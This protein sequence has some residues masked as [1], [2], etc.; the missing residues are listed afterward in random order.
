[1]LLCFVPLYL[2]SSTAS[3]SLVNH[4]WKLWNENRLHEVERTFLD[5]TKADPN[6]QRAFFSLSYLYTLQ[7]KS[8]KAWEMYNS[9]VERSANQYPYLFAVWSS[10]KFRQNPAPEKAGII[11]LLSKI[12]K[13]EKAA[14]KLQASAFEMLGSY[15][16][17]RNDINTSKKYYDKIKSI[18]SWKLIGPF[19]NTSASGYDNIFPPETEFKA[20]RQYHGKNDI[21]V[22]WFDFKTIRNDRW[23][24]F[25]RYFGYDDAVFYANTFV[26]S[27]TKQNVQVRV[28]TSGSLKT[29]LNDQLIIAIHDEN[30]NDLDTYVAETELQAGW[31]RILIKCGYSEITNCNFMFR[32][33]D[34]NGIP[35]DNITVSTEPQ[36][37]SIVNN[38]PVTMIENFAERYLK[39]QL[40]EHPDHIENYFL[41]SDAYLRNDKASEAEEVV[42]RLLKM[43][44]NCSMAYYQLIE[45]YF[46]GEKG[47][48]VADIYEKLASLDPTIPS[49]IEYQYYQ[50]IKNEDYDNAEM[51]L[52]EYARIFP[53][54]KKTYVLYIDFY[55]KKKQVDQ[56][57]RIAN[58]AYTKYPD[59][60]Q[61]VNLR[62]AVLL[63][64]ERKYDSAISLI[65]DYLD[66]EYT[67]DG[68]YAL[69]EMYLRANNVKEFER[70]Y[71]KL[72][73]LMPTSPGYY[74][75]LAEVYVQLQQYANAEATVRKALEITPANSVCLEKLGT[76]LRMMDK[77]E[78]A[79]KTFR[80]ALVNQPTKYDSRENLRELESKPFIFS[81][82]RS[83]D[84][85]YVIK[86]APA[87]EK[88]PDDAAI[89]VLDDTKR[90][91]YPE[92]ASEYSREIV[93]KMFN[94][95]GVDYFKEYW[96]EYN[97]HSEN[98]IVERAVVIKK[99][100][101]ETKADINTNQIVFKSL[102]V[103]DVIH[104][105]WRVKNYYNGKLSRHFWDQVSFNGFLPMAFVR[106]S[107]IVPAGK[108]FSYRMQN[109]TLVPGIDSL[110]DGVR[111]T[112]TRE[113]VPS[114]DIEQNMPGT[115]DIGVMLH[116]S[117]IPSWDY[118]V[119][120]YSDLAREKTRSSY[121]I[122]EQIKELFA[123]KENAGQE[124][125]IRTIYNYITEKIRYSNVSFRQSAYIP[126]SA[127]NVMVHKL[128]DCKD[129]ATL[130]IAMLNEVGIHAY[131]VLVNT[132]GEGYNNSILPSIT[133]NHC[134]VAVETDSGTKYM[135]LT[136]Y[137]YPYGSI[138]EMDQGAF[139]LMIKPGVKEPFHLMPS[140]FMARNII[141][142]QELT[143][144]NDNNVTVKISSNRTG[145]PAASQR[146]T[147][148]NLAKKDQEK[149]LL[150][151][152]TDDYATVKIQSFDFDQLDTP[153]AAITFKYSLTAF[154]FVTKAGG[155]SIVKNIWTDKFLAIEALSYEKRDY[156]FYFYPGTDTTKETLTINFDPS[157]RPVDLKPSSVITSKF[158]DY[159]LTYSSA[160]G[161]ITGT[162]ECVFKKEIIQPEEYLEFKEFYNK[163][164]LEDAA[165]IVL[166]NEPAPKK[167]AKKTKQL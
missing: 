89:Y 64:T 52:Q 49:V 109:S 28:G 77:K 80:E 103:G 13:D 121:E 108:Q 39:E 26:F 90:V 161:V 95:R 75:Q 157:L 82:F 36:E 122:K 71:N 119:Q 25:T 58:E 2:F 106:Y 146:D 155:L 68:V 51:K 14:G 59:E 107:I 166:T 99:D 42:H 72:F 101:G 143:I 111:Y 33:T 9:G 88:Y 118:I 93:V 147:Y 100:G 35:L 74:L 141:R 19:D 94:S 29:F 138:P 159:K 151:W 164:L 124:E 149:Q 145:S 10:E 43:M 37:Y 79:K 154:N 148:R 127:R 84:I 137:N 112:W 163:V 38:A 152:L 67:T 54:D 44:P 158:G 117:S 22:A 62:S 86:H 104:I 131:H 24:D 5:A 81:N 162:R 70:E 167:T 123:G 57:I 126:Q 41:L 91:V 40:E 150:K 21:P 4:G 78:E 165:S 23:I 102:E 76:I 128:G 20:N 34:K 30:N 60:W 140:Q 156:P 31:N 113:N 142:T 27:K 144:G 97:S 153:A 65:E 1:M 85:G 15:Y 61:F 12:S 87:A 83:M 50:F 135:D 110:S 133:F 11:D 48:E 92:G 63:Q 114:I 55:S 130:C 7:S 45:T 56:L 105:K 46:R 136:A 8:G 115:N 73:E 17:K 132:R 66:R 129:V 134:I 116:I 16:E 160:K 120:W 53:G 139:A 96:V 47:G 6:D 3:D 69:A 18:S 32:L 98:L 125:K